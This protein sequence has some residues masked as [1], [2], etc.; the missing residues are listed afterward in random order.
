MAGRYS[1]DDLMVAVEDGDE[2]ISPDPRVS[3]KSIAEPSDFTPVAVRA[4]DAGGC[5]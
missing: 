4:E 5:R 1:D 3:S 2:D